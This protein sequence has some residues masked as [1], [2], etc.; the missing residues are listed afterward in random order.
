MTPVAEIVEVTTLEQ[1][2]QVRALLRSYQA[3]LAE[4]YRFPDREWQSL[5]SEYRPPGGALLMATVAGEPRGC[6][7]LRAFPL[8]GACEMTR[9]YVLPASRG[10]KLG[11]ILI[12]H[13]IEAARRI[14]YTRIRLDTY[15][16]TMGAAVNLYR[17]FGFVDVPAAPMAPV[18]GL[19][20]MELF[21]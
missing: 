8:P 9:L 20:Y 13:V 18:D 15:P 21:L 12:E 5:P 1:V 19:L 7:G 6:V 3:E 11:R 17:R 2:E 10:D 14:G 4:Q 16:F